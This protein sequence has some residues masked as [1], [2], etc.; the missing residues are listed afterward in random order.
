MLDSQYF[1]TPVE[2]VSD[3]IPLLYQ[4]GYLTIKSY[5]PE[6]NQYVIGFP[7]T[8]VR[9][10]FSETLMKRYA[11]SDKGI[12]NSIFRRAVVTAVKEDNPEILLQHLKDFLCK[13]SYPNAADTPE[14][15]YQNLLYAILATCGLNVQTEIRTSSGRIDFVVIS[16]KTIFLFEFKLNKSAEEALRQIDEKEYEKKFSFDGKHVW[17]IGVNFSSEVRTVDEWKIE[18]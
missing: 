6:F 1:D 12:E 18:E 17:K 13:I 10:G 16:P 2:R 9:T 11:V 8:E 3:I 4:S 5:D 14:W 15:Y 7:N